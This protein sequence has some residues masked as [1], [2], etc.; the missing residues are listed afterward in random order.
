MNPHPDDLP[1][2]VPLP[3][4]TFKDRHIGMLCLMAV[5]AAGPTG[6]IQLGIEWAIPVVI[7]QAWAYGGLAKSF[8]ELRRRNWEAEHPSAAR[9][10]R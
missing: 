5:L 8:K 9:F 1:P 4:V 3:P 2:P 10:L 6:G 7:A